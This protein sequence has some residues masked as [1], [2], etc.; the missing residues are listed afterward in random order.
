MEIKSIHSDFNSVLY[1]FIAA[2]VDN[3]DDAKDIR[4]EVF[5]KIATK[6]DSLTNSEKLRSWIFTVARNTIIDYYRKNGKEKHVD[7]EDSLAEEVRASEETDTTKGLDR[8]L[9]SFIEKLP[10]EYRDIIIDSEIK[11]I[12]QKDLAEKYN[13]AYP[14]VRS[15]VQRGRTRL[16]ELLLDCCKIEADSR[17]NIIAA[18]AKNKSDES[19]LNCP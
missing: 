18:V 3:A 1:G 12:K 8:C 15:R 17:G 4:Q 16:K 6:L 7:M 5:I 2:R 9:I 13:L 19:L 14:T 10:D 11:G